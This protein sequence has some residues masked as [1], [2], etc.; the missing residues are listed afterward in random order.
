MGKAS[1]LLKCVIHTIFFAKSLPVG[2]DISPPCLFNVKERVNAFKTYCNNMA[3]SVM[4][5]L[6]YRR[7][8][9][10]TGPTFAHT[11]ELT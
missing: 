5:R 10:S 11:K 9:P 3:G 2:F 6:T 4:G 7:R 8:Q 1:N